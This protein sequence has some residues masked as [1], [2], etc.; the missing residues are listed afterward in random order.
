MKKLRS[1]FNKSF[2]TSFQILSDLH[3]EVGQQYLSYEIPPSAPYLILGGDIGR[4]IDFDSY[5]AFLARQTNN[6]KTVF[7]VLGNHEFCGLSSAGALEQAKK[8]EAEPILGGKLILLH[9]KRFDFPDSSI[10]ILGCTLWSRILEEAREIVQMKVKDFQKIEDRTVDAHNRDHESDVTWLRA[11][12]EEIRK[13]NEGMG[14][15]ECQG[16][17]LVITHHAPSI[18]ETARPEQVDNPWSSAFATDLLRD[19][20]WPNVKMWIFGHTHFTTEFEKCG[21]RV[22][23]NQRGYVLPG[24]VEV[25]NKE[26]DA[27]KRFD[28][29]KIV[30][31]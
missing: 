27:K 9:Q 2:S 18:Q 17:I 7:L 31:L 13:E 21:I 4:L 25:K 6:F 24:T 28:V 5:L 11:Q 14:K 29:R 1:L 19:G 8:L 10:T 15:D 16:D 26:K 3:L 30:S 20:G 23:S 22:V 12:V